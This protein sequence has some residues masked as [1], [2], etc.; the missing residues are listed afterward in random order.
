MANP[1]RNW[2]I[3]LGYANTDRTRTNVL[4]EGEPWW[5][6]R[7]ALWESLNTLYTTRTGQPS[8][9]TQPRVDA[10]GAVTNPPVADRIAPYDR[11]HNEMRRE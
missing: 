1:N 9:C 7:L 11:E 8:L 6:A 2:S 3:R 4:N 10:S 5:A